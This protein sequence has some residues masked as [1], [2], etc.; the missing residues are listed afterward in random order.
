M[1]AAVLQF[2]KG[3]LEI[4]YIYLKTKHNAYQLALVIVMEILQINQTLPASNVQL[5]SLIV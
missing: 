3:A 4:I 5:I 2:V 1:I